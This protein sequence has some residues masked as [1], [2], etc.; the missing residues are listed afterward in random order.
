MSFYDADPHPTW[1]VF[2][3]I[4]GGPS[5]NPAKK[6]AQKPQWANVDPHEPKTSIISDLPHLSELAG[7]FDW[8][9]SCI[10]IP[11][12]NEPVE[13]GL[14]D[15]QGDFRLP[16]DR[17]FG[18]YPSYA[19]AERT[20]NKQYGLNCHAKCYQLLRNRLAYTLQYQ[21]IWPKLAAAN[22]DSECLNSDYGGMTEYHEHVRSTGNGNA[23]LL[24]LHIRK[25]GLAALCFLS[26]AAMSM[27][28][29]ACVTF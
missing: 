13:L 22:D 2:C 24:S 28:S 20:P 3:L 11:E 4:C 1:D 10:G 19:Q 12:D 16:G 15:G 14:Y 25:C 6:P 21:H 17:L 7:Q 29:L 8:L 26:R 27:T 5:L 18:P 9:D 23:E